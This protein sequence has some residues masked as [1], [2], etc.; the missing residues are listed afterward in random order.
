MEKLKLREHS[1]DEITPVIE[2]LIEKNYLRE[3]RFAECL[4]GTRLN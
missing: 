1:E 3:Q 2:Y 4:F